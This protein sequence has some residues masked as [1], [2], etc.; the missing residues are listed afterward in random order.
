MAQTITG[1]GLV[2]NAA[3]DMA[4]QAALAPW[5]R[6]ASAPITPMQHPNSPAAPWYAD[7]MAQQQASQ[8]AMVRQ[9]KDEQA[10]KAQ[11]AAQAA[12][13]EA[14]RHAGDDNRSSW[15]KFR[16]HPTHGD[17]YVVDMLSGGTRG[18]AQRTGL[19]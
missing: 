13:D 2:Q 7:Q 5:L 19:K 1:G 16:D 8:A 11:A 17:S 15:V 12:A 6:Q 14:A 9:W 4:Q 10:A 18:L 3:P